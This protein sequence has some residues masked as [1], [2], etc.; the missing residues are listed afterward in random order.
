MPDIDSVDDI[1]V[2]LASDGRA[3]RP[4]TYAVPA[5]GLNTKQAAKAYVDSKTGGVCDAGDKKDRGA[6]YAAKVADLIRQEGVVVHA[7]G[8]GSQNH[9]DPGALRV[10]AAVAG[11]TDALI[12]RQNYSIT[13]GDLSTP[14][15]QFAEDQGNL[16]QTFS[17]LAGQS[18]P[19]VTL[20]KPHLIDPT[21]S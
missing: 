2:I 10:T 8:L 18:G 6:A 20:G 12:C 3:G 7:L 15:G 4:I 17:F 19:V 11:A 21:K 9:Y 14:S 16:P 5:L 13:A 1:V